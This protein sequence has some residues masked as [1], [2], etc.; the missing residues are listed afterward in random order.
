M[1]PKYNKFYYRPLPKC[2]QVGESTIE[3]TGIFAAEDIKE[4]VDLGMTHINVPIIH[5]YVR[6]ALGGFVNHDPKANCYLEQ[7]LDWDD[8]RTYH[9]ITDRAI[10]EGEEI[11]LDYHIDEGV[12][13]GE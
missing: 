10:K 9:L 12:E 5:G 11:T 6:T 8:Y 13:D 7:K 4:D 2:L 1:T 3:G